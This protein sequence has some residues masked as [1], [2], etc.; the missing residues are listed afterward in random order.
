M[1]FSPR[2]FE[3]NSVRAVGGADEMKSFT[4]ELRTDEVTSGRRSNDAARIENPNRSRTICV[5]RYDADPKVR[6]G[7]V[8]AR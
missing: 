4:A 2:V 7:G 5:N 6:I 8:L 3:N 1:L